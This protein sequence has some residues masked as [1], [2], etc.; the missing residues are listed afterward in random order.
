MIK[1]LI[2]L[3]ICG[4]MKKRRTVL[5]SWGNFLPKTHLTCPT[6]SCFTQFTDSWKLVK[7]ECFFPLVTIWTLWFFGVWFFPYNFI[8]SCSN[9]KINTSFEICIQFA[10]QWWYYLPHKTLFKACYDVLNIF[11]PISS[12][13]FWIFF[14]NFQLAI[15]WVK[16]NQMR[17]VRWVLNRKLP[18]DSKTVL[19][20]YIWLH[21]HREIKHFINDAN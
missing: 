6:W 10:V 14:N 18:E 1:C 8:I 13:K 5:N 19:L 17:Q 3:W 16:L 15:T 2:S 12:G 9:D 20:F 11:I 7:R 21:I 4:P